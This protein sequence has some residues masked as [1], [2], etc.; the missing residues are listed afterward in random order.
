MCPVDQ[1]EE[2]R[3][4]LSGAPL[5]KERSQVRAEEPGDPQP[6]AQLKQLPG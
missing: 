4:P 3:Q 2:T 6:G 5:S 1:N